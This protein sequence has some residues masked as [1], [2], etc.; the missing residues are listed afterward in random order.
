[1]G[2]EAELYQDDSYNLSQQRDAAELQ[3]YAR[4]TLIAFIFA[5][6][7]FIVSMVIGMMLP[8]GNPVKMFFM[9]EVIPGLTL[10]SLI[11]L[12]LATPVQFIIGWRFYR[13]SYKSLRYAKSANVS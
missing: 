10:E 7:I 9:M 11:A 1:M 13:G 5:L 12:I 2:Y 6:P 8:D 3:A 4:Q